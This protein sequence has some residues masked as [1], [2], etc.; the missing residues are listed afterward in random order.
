MRGLFDHEKEQLVQRTVKDDIGLEVITP[1]YTGVD[2]AGKLKGLLINR[3][4][5][6]FEYKESGMHHTPK[7]EKQDVEGVIFATEGK[8]IL[9]EEGLAK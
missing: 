8:C 1:L 6:S 5:I 4:R 2:K 7:G 3:G 9:K